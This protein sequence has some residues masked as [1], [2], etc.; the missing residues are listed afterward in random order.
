M[1]GTKSASLAGRITRARQ[2]SGLSKTEFAARLGV[3]LRA[4]SY[5]ENGEREP[6][7]Y[8]VKSIARVTK[9][10]MEFFY[11]EEVAA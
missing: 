10:P 11:P 2:L 7:G 9:Q 8:L 1:T 4:V 6:R 5:W 3:S